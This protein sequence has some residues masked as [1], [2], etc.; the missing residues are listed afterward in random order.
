[1]KRP[2]L[3]LLVSCN[4]RIIDSVITPAP[5]T[6]TSTRPRMKTAKLIACDETNAPTVKNNDDARVMTPGE[7]IMASRPTSGDMDATAMRYALVNHIAPS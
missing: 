6:P 2:L 5:P 4:T 1:M 3:L 7:K